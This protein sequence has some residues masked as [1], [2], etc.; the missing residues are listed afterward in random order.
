MFFI[1]VDPGVAGG[2]AV[3]DDSGQHV[4]THKMPETRRDLLDIL[5]PF[6]QAVFQGRP[7]RCMVEK[8][9]AGV[10][11]RPGARMGVVSA[12]TFGRNVERVHMA[13][14]A[15]GVP[16]DEVLPAKWQLALGCRTGGDKNI[17]KARAQ[18]LFPGLKVTHAIADALLIAEF[19]RRTERGSIS[20]PASR[21][22]F[23]GKEEGRAEEGR[24]EERAE[25]GRTEVAA[26]GRK[27][28]RH[29]AAPAARAVAG[30]RGRSR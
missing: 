19:C 9:H 22:L 23:D 7:A 27:A 8:V 16:Y 4:A 1:G 12:F 13:L 6:N 30:R 28:G 25:E 5:Q 17:S 11:G 20:A 24:K 3:I 26:S 21:G 2:I 10:F 18:E 15:A 29:T 14:V